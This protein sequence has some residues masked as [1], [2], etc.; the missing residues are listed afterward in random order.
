MLRQSRVPRARAWPL[1]AAL[2]LLAAACGGGDFVPVEGVIDRETF[3]AA[4]VDLR[5]ETLAGSDLAL[6][7]EERDRVLASHGVDAKSLLTF[8]EAYGR[9]LDFMNEVWT[10]I[11]S[12]LEARSAPDASELP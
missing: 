2:S 4:Y 11:E 6:P 3:I 5:A 8:V 1:A 9:D 7:D 10:E 12:R